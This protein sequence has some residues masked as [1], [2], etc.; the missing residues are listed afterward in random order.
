MRPLCSAKVGYFY[1]LKFL[2]AIKYLMDRK[3]GV[4]LGALVVCSFVN[5][6][7]FLPKRSPEIDQTL[8]PVSQRK[9][10]SDAV[11]RGS[12]LFA[13]KNSC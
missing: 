4:R 5:F 7:V 6:D 11:E 2:A 8:H 9:S 10:R 13:Y 1:D 3:Q 12:T